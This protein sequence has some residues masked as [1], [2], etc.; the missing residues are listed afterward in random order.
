MI[1]RPA[2]DPVIWGSPRT[3]SRTIIFNLPGL[4]SFYQMTVTGIIIV[5]AVLL[6]RVTDHRK[7]R[8]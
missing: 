6:N 5:A 2:S 7:G 1:S 3:W 4:C 8:G